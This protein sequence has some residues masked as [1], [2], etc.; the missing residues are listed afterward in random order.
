MQFRGQGS[1]SRPIFFIVI[2]IRWKLLSALI[3]VVVKW[4][5]WNFAQGTTAVF[6]CGFNAIQWNYMKNNF[7]SHLNYGGKIVREMGPWPV[8]WDA[9]PLIWHRYN[10]S[11]GTCANCIGPYSYDKLLNSPR[12][13]AVRLSVGFGTWL[14]IGWP[15]LYLVGLNIV[16]DCHS[17]NK[18]PANMPGGNL[19]LYSKSKF[20]DSHLGC[21]C[22]CARGLWKGLAERLYSVIL[23]VVL[24][25]CKETVKGSTLTRSQTELC[26]V[27]SQ[28]CQVIQLSQ[29][30]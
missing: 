4:L 17:T 19:H 5:L 24:W 20:V 22:D 29:C 26:V 30:H 11:Q 3:Q 18:L 16:W 12:L 21:R 7:P 15:L 8:K 9:L 10:D 1:I 28:Q 27:T 14:P 23:C 25:L 6:F 2:Q 13:V